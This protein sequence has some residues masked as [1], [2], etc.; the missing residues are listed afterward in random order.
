[1]IPEN[2]NLFEMEPMKYFSFPS[3]YDSKKK[4]ERIRFLL[5]SG[6]YIYSL[7]TD[8]N[9]GRMVF[10]GKRLA[11]QS[12]T[13]SKKTGTYSEFQDKVMFS[14]A[15]RQAFTDTTVLLGEIYMEGG[16]DKDVGTILRCLSDKALARQKEDPTKILHYRIFDCLYYNGTSLL[17]APISERIKYLKP[18]V[19]AINSPLVD[20]VQ[21]YEAKSESFFGKLAKI[22]DDGGEGVVLYD[23][24]MTPCQGRTP[25][26]QTLKV[27][28]EMAVDADCFIYGTVPP[29]RNYTGKELN[30]W[31]YW[32]DEHTGEKLLGCY[33]MDYRNG[34]LITPITKNYYYDWPSAIKCA[35]WD[36][37]GKPLILCRCSG[38]TEEMKEGLRDN[39]EAW[40][41]MPIRITGMMLSV[42]EDPRT[43]E[44]SYS[45]RHPKLAT[46]RD[47]DLAL[48]DCTLK[49]LIG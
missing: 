27:K 41:K 10:Q 45:I 13:I 29:E 33:A 20:Y 23:K 25:S 32:L 47:T 26:W 7:K 4:Q 12:R 37:E 21:Y 28:Q 40:D 46:I 19:E 42:T 3:L 8:G 36:E 38:I 2:V 43:H 1:M 11:L 18:A 39:Y 9:L 48:E 30:T 49:K 6:N 31:E 34:A 24:H 16:R 44:K 5:D 15:M 22:F 35:V 14:A 17:N